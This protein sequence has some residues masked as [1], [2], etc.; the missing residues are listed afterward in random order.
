M[1]RTVVGLLLVL[2]VLMQISACTVVENDTDKITFENLDGY[3]V[4]LEDAVI[5]SGFGEPDEEYNYPMDLKTKANLYD[6]VVSEVSVYIAA[7]WDE[8]KISADGVLYTEFMENAYGADIVDIDADDRYKEIAVYSDGP[9][10]DPSVRFFRFDGK[11]II[12]LTAQDGELGFY[13]N[14]IYGYYDAD[15]DDVYPTYGAIWTD[16]DGRIVNSFGNVGFTKE[17]IAYRY[18]VLDGN[19]FKKVDI[20]SPYDEEKEYIVDEEITAYFVP[21]AEKPDKD[22]NI[23]TVYQFADEQKLRFNEGDTIQFY[24]CEAFNY[25]YYV[26][27]GGVKGILYFWMGD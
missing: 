13:D 18:Y 17:R 24:N 3:F 1:K 6:D 22:F 5:E 20:K 27:V 9:S 10:L 15:E 7:S 12:P 25:P 19:T 23:V 14:E 11:E 16:C 26:K 21:L 8:V 4:P 2:F